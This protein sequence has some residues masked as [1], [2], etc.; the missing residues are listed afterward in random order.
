MR[1]AQTAHDNIVGFVIPVQFVEDSGAAS[2]TRVDHV[3][4]FRNRPGLKF[5]GRIHEQILGSL[6][7]SGGDIARCNAVVLHSGYDTSIEGQARKRE[8]DERLLALELS[9]NPDDP[10][11]N[12]NRGM[13]SHYA[14]DHKDA[15]DWLR[16][17]L[18]LAN[19]SDSIVRKAYALL[20][21]AAS[22]RRLLQEFEGAR[23]RTRNLSQ[24]SGCSSV[25]PH[26]RG[27]PMQNAAISD[28]LMQHP[29]T[30]QHRYRDSRSK[31]FPQSGRR[32]PL[33]L[34]TFRVRGSGGW[35]VQAGP[36]FWKTGL[37]SSTLHWRRRTD[38]LDTDLSKGSDKA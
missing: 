5:T 32:M 15:V 14:G 12:F 36:K 2:G 28:V 27:T 23:Q 33:G 19:P 13:T 17:S 7:A 26:R 38:N 16:R 4:L 34:A 6:R 31:G 29:T 37:C 3:K 1:A 10:F 24:R 25:A 8:R 30:F 22:L 35:A 20:A 18:T 11:A 21:I 9:E